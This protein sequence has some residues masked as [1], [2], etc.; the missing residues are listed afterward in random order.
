VLV[1]LSTFL[2]AIGF[3]IL[4][5]G[6]HIR[7]IAI[8]NV[9]FYLSCGAVILAIKEF[10][11]NLKRVFTLFLISLLF[12]SSISTAFFYKLA[13]METDTRARLAWGSPEVCVQKAL[14]ECNTGIDSSIR[15]IMDGCVDEWAYALF[16]KGIANIPYEK[17]AVTEQGQLYL[18][19]FVLKLFN[20]FN[21]YPLIV[22]NAMS[23]LITALLLYIFCRHYINSQ[24][25]IFAAIGVLF[26]PEGILWAGVLHKDS[27]VLLLIMLLVF[28]YI[29]IFKE[30]RY[31]YY[32]LMI[33]TFYS[34]SF[35]RSG[36]VLA[37]LLTGFLVSLWI[38][39][40][41]SGS[42]LFIGI[43]VFAALIFSALF[44]RAVV[45]DISNK[46][47]FKPIDKLF[48]GSSARLDSQN[49]TY[50]TT[51]ENSYI[52]RV[53]GGD[54]T[55]QK[56]YYAPIRLAMLLISP[57]PPWMVRHW[58]DYFILPS[59]WVVMLMMP[60]ALLGFFRLGNTGDLNKI[61]TL[62]FIALSI[63]IAF[64]GP[65]L[66]ERYRLM[67]MPMYFS[68]AGQ[69]FVTKKTSFHLILFICMFVGT[70][71]LYLVYLVIK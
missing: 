68:I 34:L 6:Y 23:N 48:I 40:K 65:F 32:I 9:L 70:L 20:V 52:E 45:Q 53:G 31:P 25:A 5:L 16:N 38:G 22:I 39:K 21:L 35:L 62:T 27:L 36:I 15:Y 59:T 57:F 41:V 50:T 49:I 29:K 18:Y 1:V 56:V 42:I 63:A 55:I 11:C 26:L 10:N 7:T 24:T 30:K 58:N 13:T 19:S 17:I 8:A 33:L 60:Y 51:K 14:D 61:F 44:P 67:L 71:I 4:D 46:V 54:L 28:S 37:M 12:L 3:Q 69:Y 66:L 43:I 64:A 47:I 2:V